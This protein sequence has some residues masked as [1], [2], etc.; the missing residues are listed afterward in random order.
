[1]FSYWFLNIFTE[2]LLLMQFYLFTL[3]FIYSHH[4]IYI[5]IWQ[6]TTWNNAEKCIE[7]SDY[8]IVS[9]QNQLKKQKERVIAVFNLLYASQNDNVANVIQCLH[10]VLQN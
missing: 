1:M 5:Y 2:K 3:H 9:N 8:V 4:F 6:I 10:I 7:M